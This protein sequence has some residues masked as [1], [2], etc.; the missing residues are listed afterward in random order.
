[1]VKVSCVGRTFKFRI[2]FEVKVGG[3][4]IVKVLS[5][6]LRGSFRLNGMGAIAPVMGED[7]RL[8]TPRTPC[9]RPARARDNR[10]YVA[11]CKDQYGFALLANITSSYRVVEI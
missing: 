5:S 9:A 10:P 11:P 1:M 2:L 8:Q 7:G 4:A 3:I 6:G